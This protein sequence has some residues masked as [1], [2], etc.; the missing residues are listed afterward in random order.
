[1]GLGA[2][3]EYRQPV[4]IR[5]LLKKEVHQDPPPSAATFWGQDSLPLKARGKKNGGACD[6][7][8]RPSAKPWR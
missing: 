6:R 1:M 3:A 2:Y 8:N 5:D 4:F 7:Q